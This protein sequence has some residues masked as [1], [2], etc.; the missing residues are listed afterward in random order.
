MGMQITDEQV[1]AIVAKSILDALP[2]A[3]RAEMLQKAITSILTPAK[4]TGYSFDRSPPRS[5]LEEQFQS[6]TAD[7]V[8]EIVRGLVAADEGL[9]GR[10]R[11]VVTAAVTKALASETL[12]DTLA[13]GILNAFTVRDR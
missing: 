12:V 10:I 9:K 4:P 2:E 7:Q 13:Q 3:Q 1:R 6:A 8:R 11:E 5:V